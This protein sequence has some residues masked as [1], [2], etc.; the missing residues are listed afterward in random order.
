MNYE[1]KGDIGL[2][3]IIEDVRNKLISEFKERLQNLLEKKENFLGEIES[4]ILEEIKYWENYK[5]KW[6]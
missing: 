3:Q 4:F 2:S 5:I 6:L 1:Y